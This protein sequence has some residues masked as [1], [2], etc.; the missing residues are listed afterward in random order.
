MPCFK[1]GKRHFNR[2]CL[3]VSRNFSDTKAKRSAVAQHRFLK[4]L[5]RNFSDTKAKQLAV[6]QHRFL[7]NTPRIF[8]D[9]KAKQLAV[10]QHRFLKNTPSGINR[11]A[12]MIDRYLLLPANLQQQFSTKMCFRKCAVFTT[13]SI[14]I[15]ALNITKPRQG[16]FGRRLSA[17]L[18]IGPHEVPFIL[19]E[20]FALVSLSQVPKKIALFSS[21]LSVDS[22]TVTILSRKMQVSED[23]AS[24]EL[25]LEEPTFH[26]KRRSSEEPNRKNILK[27]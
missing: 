14:D 5:P 17:W 16:R 10:A 19:L 23:K 1:C 2:K 12:A 27:G 15:S 22:I 21:S 18:L 6:A 11:E 7:K 9:T 4:N 13:K 8:S 26:L 3:G 20:A 25:Q 24:E